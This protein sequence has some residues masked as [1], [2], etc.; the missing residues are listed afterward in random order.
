MLSI[1]ILR[2]CGEAQKDNAHVFKEEAEG[3]G[4]CL[5]KRGPER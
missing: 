2:E 3:A 5:D 1:V 4:P